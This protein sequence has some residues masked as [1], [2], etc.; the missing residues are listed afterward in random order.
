MAPRTRRGKIRGNGDGALYY[1]EARDRWIGVATVPDPAAKDRRKR[2][3]VTGKDKAAAKAKLDEILNKIKE[4]TPAGSATETV[5]D[6]LRQWLAHGLDRRKIKSENTVDGLAWAVGKQL[7]PAIGGYRLR[8]LECEH[9]EAMLAAMTARGMSSSSLTRVHTTLTRA[10]KWAQRRRK[11][12]RNVSELVETP[13]GTQRPS[14][15]LTVRQVQTVLNTVR[16]D[17]LEALWNPRVRPW[18]APRRTHRAAV[19]TRRPRRWRDHRV[20][21]AQAP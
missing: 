13:V 8:N 15:A 12:S 18:H 4:G 2:V 17:R 11:V 7:I 1:S 5:A 3:K 6:V 14:K 10:L 19:G 16:D 21:V 9:V 20:G